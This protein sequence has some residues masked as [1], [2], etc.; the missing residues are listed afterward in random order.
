MHWSQ[1]VGLD[2]LWIT[3]SSL[4]W[5]SKAVTPDALKSSRST[6]LPGQDSMVCS[7]AKTKQKKDFQPT[8]TNVSNNNWDALLLIRFEVRFSKG[9]SS[10]CVVGDKRL[11]RRLPLTSS[12]IV[13]VDLEKGGDR[14]AVVGWGSLEWRELWVVQDLRWICAGWQNDGRMDPS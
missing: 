4:L 11:C 7:K 3:A 5:P 13:V 14:A 6:T 8:S 12:R 10:S 9:S 1:A 2:R